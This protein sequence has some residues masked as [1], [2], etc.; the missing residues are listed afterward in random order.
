MIDKTMLSKRKNLLPYLMIM[1]LF[2]GGCSS[3]SGKFACGDSIGANCVMLSEVDKRIDSGEIE[4]SYKDKRCSD[5]RCKS[6]ANLEA[7]PTLKNNKT[8]KALI[9]DEESTPDLV[10]GH[11]L[12]LK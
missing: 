8:H 6:N 9:V 10:E 7:W 5:S 11:Y 12:M 4:E 1:P 3:Y 2:L